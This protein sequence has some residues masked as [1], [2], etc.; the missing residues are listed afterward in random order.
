[1]FEEIELPIREPSH[2]HFLLERYVFQDGELTVDVRPFRQSRRA[3]IT[4]SNVIGLT[5]MED[6]FGCDG[7]QITLDDQA[8]KPTGLSSS[9]SSETLTKVKRVPEPFVGSVADHRHYWLNLREYQISLVATA[10]PEIEL[11]SDWTG[12]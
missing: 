4:F 5:M 9:D 11:L 6:V 3:R 7:G 2:G 8:S 10:E 12:E 1:M